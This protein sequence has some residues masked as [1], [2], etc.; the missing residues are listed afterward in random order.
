MRISR[1]IVIGFVLLTAFTVGAFAAGGAE[2]ASLEGMPTLNVTTHSGTSSAVQPAS[3]D[4][5][6]YQELEKASGIHIEWDVIQTTSY[7]EVMRARLAAGIDLPDLINMSNLGDI[8]VYGRDGLIIPLNDLLT[9]YAPRITAWWAE[10]NN[11]VYKI[12]DTS[13]DGNIYG[14]SGYV[15]KQYLSM[16]HI[17]NTEWLK[18]VGINKLP[19]TQAEMVNAL[20]LFRDSDP[21]GNGK[22]DE[23]P[24][25]PAAGRSYLKILGNQY[26]FEFSI[27]SEFQV[28]NAG[29]IYWAPMAPRYKEYLAFL[30]MLYSEGLL[31][32]AYSTDS[33]TQTAE[34]VGNDVVGMITCWAT[35]AKIYT[36]IHPDANGSLEKP[37]W[38]NGPPIEGPSGD[39]YFLKREISGGNQMGVT[40]DCKTPEIAVEWIDFIRNSN[41][42]LMLQNFGVEGITYNMVNGEIVPISSPD[43]SFETRLRE[44][45]GSGPPYAHMQWGYAWDF[46]NPPWA[47]A[48]KDSYQKYYKSPSFPQIPS[49][50]AEQD[51]LN[52][53]WTDLDTYHLEWF[54]KFVTGE[55]PLDKFDTFVATLRRLGA[56]EVIAVRQQQYERFKK[57]GVSR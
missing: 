6:V 12:L 53:L 13:P 42:A 40:K 2:A 23:I 28:D 18:T 51:T 43:K 56:D 8:G 47:V 35:F 36:P 17:W 22:A 10:G 57:F 24:L 3:N 34:K 50:A 9:K 7:Q 38:E 4:L 45:G 20:K 1:S 26:G 19:E 21:N 14:V 44:I 33:W 5:P 52:R 41:E 46:W 27:A 30:N 55:E 29:K 37:F 25:V 11:N 32:K 54:D 15:E 48:N 39:K 16:G 49:T 31:D